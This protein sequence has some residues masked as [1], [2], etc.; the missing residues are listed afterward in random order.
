[1]GELTRLRDELR[2]V[3]VFYSAGWTRPDPEAMEFLDFHADRY[4]Q[5]LTTLDGLLRDRPRPR[6]LEVGPSPPLAAVILGRHSVD[7]QAV[8]GA[9]RLDGTKEPRT[10]YELRTRLDGREAR[11]SVEAG[12]D[13]EHDALPFPDESFDVVLL[14]EVI[15][16]LATSPVPALHELMRVLKP[17]GVLVLTTDHASSLIKLAKLLLLRPIYWPYPR[18]SFGERHHREFL[19]REIQELLEGTGFEGVAVRSFDMRPYHLDNAPLKWLGYSVANALTR[20]P[21]LG[22]YR[23]HILATA[24]KGRP[25]T[26]DLPWLLCGRR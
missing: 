13:L 21:P 10:A 12:V 5:T 18:S 4:L 9:C 3:E 20:V 14:L 2:R 24:R 1:M 25:R 15:E 7:Y 22:R 17:G 16:H 19:V 23:R 8:S 11:L 6:L 26:P